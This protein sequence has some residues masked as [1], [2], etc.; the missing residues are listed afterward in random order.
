VDHL[1]LHCEVASAIWIVF[2]SRFGLSWVMRR[3]VVDLYTCWWTAGSFWSA[4]VWKMV[5]FIV[6]MEGKER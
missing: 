6:S 4:T 5:P 3:R 1:L 2:F